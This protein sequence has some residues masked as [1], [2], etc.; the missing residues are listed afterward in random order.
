VPWSTR[1]VLS[2]A[3]LRA[4]WER[5]LLVRFVRLTRRG[6]AEKNLQ[7]PPPLEVHGRDTTTVSAPLL[8]SE[9]SRG[10]LSLPFQR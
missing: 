10:P 3:I 7:F 9:V 1:L 6:V 5:F 2:P 4:T 8:E